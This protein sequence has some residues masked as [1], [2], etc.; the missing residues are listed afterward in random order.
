MSIPLRRI[1]AAGMDF[2]GIAI[3]CHHASGSLARN[4]YDGG[5]K[6]V[7]ILVALL[8]NDVTVEHNGSPVKIKLEQQKT[9][10]Q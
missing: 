5:F 10:I 9:E 7:A 8:P 2:F 4:A 3:N 6:S 1:R